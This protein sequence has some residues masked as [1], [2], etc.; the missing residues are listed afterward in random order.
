MS[1]LKM[2]GEC[3][4]AIAG[5]EDGRGAQNNKCMQ[6]LESGKGKEMGDAKEP[7]EGT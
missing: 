6:S 3:Q 5:Y 2:T 4:P 7:P 1:E